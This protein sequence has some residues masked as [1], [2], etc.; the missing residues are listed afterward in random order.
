MAGQ[1]DG[2]DRRLAVADHFDAMAGLDQRG[3]RQH[4]VDVVVLGD[5][6]RQAPASVAARWRGLCRRACRLRWRGAGFALV[7]EQRA[8]Q[9]FAAHR[10]GQECAHSRG[11]EFAEHAAVGRRDQRDRL[12]A[13]R[14]RLSRRRLS[15][16][17][18]A[19]LQRGVDK[20]RVAA[21]GV[22]TP[23]AATVAAISAEPP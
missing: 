14:S 3:P 2:V 16:L 10:P 15:N 13:R 12:G 7:A 19:V 22:R 1:R 23:P 9:R 20:Q 8:K 18:F 4:G 5:Q 6:D 11:A 17:P 21:V